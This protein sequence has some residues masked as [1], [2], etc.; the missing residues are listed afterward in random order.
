MPHR[1]EFS[2]K[3]RRAVHDRANG[4]CEECKAV[5]K[6]SEGEYDHILP[7]ALGGEPTQANCQLICK[8]CHRAKTTNDVRRIRK[9]DRQRDNHIG[10]MRPKRKI[11]SRGFS[12]SCKPPVIA[13]KSLPPRE[14]YK[15]MEN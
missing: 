8:V 3:T 4:Y 1:L 15:E 9:A 11:K 14:I 6:I 2:R 5:L 12:R 10:T 13:T 7:D